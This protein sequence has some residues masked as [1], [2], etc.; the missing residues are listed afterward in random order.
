MRI[1]TKLALGVLGLGGLSFAA[2]QNL[3]MQDRNFI[4]DAA[5]G[6]M[7][8]VHMGHLGVDRGASEAVKSFSQ[9]LINDHTKANEELE[10]LAARK[11]VTLPPDDA[12]MA[13]ST[14][15]ASKSGAEFDRE[16]ARTAVEDHRKDIAAF[17]KEASSGSDP[18]VKRWAEKTLP[19][20]RSHLAASEALPR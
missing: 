6:G 3:S 8:E 12:K 19:T 11:G 9:R 7:M 15:L 18:E 17:E 13:F 10:A 14:P 1:Y 4:Q 20:L 5:K 2:A 16:F